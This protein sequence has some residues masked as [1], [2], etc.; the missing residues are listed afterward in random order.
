MTGFLEDAGI[1]VIGDDGRSLVSREFSA[2][3]PKA[4]DIEA[5]GRALE[6]GPRRH[7]ASRETYSKCPTPSTRAMRK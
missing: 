3:R 5:Y 2:L 4:S 1:S 6:S 7:M